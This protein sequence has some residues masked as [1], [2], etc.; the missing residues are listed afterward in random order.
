MPAPKPLRLCAS[1]L[2]PP[3]LARVGLAFFAVLSMVAAL[4]A[5]A[6]PAD[7]ARTP[8]PTT[9][10][11]PAQPMAAPTSDPAIVAPIVTAVIATPTP[12]PRETA[13]PFDL[14]AAGGGTVSLSDLLEGK[15]AAVMVFYRGLF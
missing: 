15:R 5:C 10:P 6:S 4:T 3:R 13:P 14:P 9:T 1:A 7:D 12:V 11:I 2:N 8:P